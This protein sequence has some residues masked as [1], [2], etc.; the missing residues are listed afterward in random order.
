VPWFGLVVVGLVLAYGQYTPLSPFLAHLPFY[1]DL[2]L[3]SRNIV[4]ADLG[5]CV[6]L[7]HW[8]EIALESPVTNAAR[9][10]RVLTVAPAVA[11]ATACVVAL[12]APVPLEQWMGVVTEVAHLGRAVAPWF[13]ASL[14]VAAG[15]VVIGV[16]YSRLAPKPRATAFAAVI[17]VDLLLFTVSSVGTWNQ[18]SATGG[19][20]TK[21]SALTVAAGT[22]FAAFDPSNEYLPQ[23]SSLGQNDLNT[24]VQLPSVEGYGSLTDDTYQT[25]TGTRTHNT[26]SP[27]ALAHGEFVPLG[28]S[29]LVTVADDLMTQ[30]GVVLPPSQVPG[31]SCAPVAAPSS[32]RR[33]WWFGQ[34]LPV[35]LASIAFPATAPARLRV[36][37][38]TQSG[39]TTW[40]PATETRVGHDL[41]I[42]FPT[43]VVGSGLV[44]AG[45]GAN[46]ATDAT[47]VTTT[48]G[49]QY[50]LDGL[51]QAALRDASFH[52]TGYRDG[53]AV[54]R[55]TVRDAPVS[56]VADKA[57]DPVRRPGSAGAGTAR[58]VSLTPWGE[59]TD[60]VTVRRPA[61]LVRSET[62]DPGWRATARS[63]VTGRARALPV[64]RVGLVEGIHLTPGTYTVT[65]TYRPASVT[66]GLVA[67]AVGGV[68]VA[69]AAVSW[70]WAPRRRRRRGAALSRPARRRGA[71]AS[72]PAAI[73]G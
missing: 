52:F 70:L 30:T 55:T 35:R 37:F 27:C 28:L 25:A 65:W 56:L 41:Q 64:V 12:A 10:A 49:V 6:L 73:R 67:T 23:M 50:V 21:A 3:Q 69:A 20:P 66:A 26:I 4:I 72:S 19:L 9:R 45:T 31:T 47:S 39:A 42:D 34:A 54:F 11:L 71:T 53:I 22:R 24:L 1:G 15:A 48:S 57:P 40:T 2:R 46:G 13:V 17:V 38:L 51:L 8:L 36:G 68:V 44:V 5:L 18:S 58:R 14:V 62:F 16:G 43:P 63:A 29:T 32:T 33:V 60:K 7:A 61:T 59:E